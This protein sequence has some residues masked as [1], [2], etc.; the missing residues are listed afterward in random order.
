[1][2]IFFNKRKIN[3]WCVKNITPDLIKSVI[4]LVLSVIILSFRLK[5]TCFSIDN[6]VD[7][8][9]IVS[10]FIVAVCG[11]I[12]TI[13]LKVVINITEDAMKISDNYANLVTKYCLEDMFE[14]SRNDNKTIH[15]PV[16]IL[17]QRKIDETPF[18]IIIDHSNKDKRYQLP[19]QIADNSSMLF[20]AHSTSIIYNNINIRVDDW[21]YLKEKNEVKLRYSKT[22]YYDSLLTNRVM[23]YP[24]K[25][26]RTIREVFEPGPLLSTLSES[27][28]S[29][30]IGF[31]G[32]IETADGFYIFVKRAKNLSIAKN[33]LSTSVSA[34]LKTKYALIKNR[35]LTL[36]GIS[37]AIKKEVYDELKI[38]IDADAGTEIDLSKSIFAFYRELS[39]GGKPQFLMYYKLKTATKTEIDKNFQILLKEKGKNKNDPIEDGSIIKFYT[40]DDLRKSE[41]DVGSIKK[42]HNEE[43]SVV[44]TISFSIACLLS[45][46]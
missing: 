20:E 1:M 29:N 40:L 36:D 3:R 23:D 43:Y 44:P 10:F 13:L 30:H 28:L 32:F 14:F 38:D 2:R 25:E 17:S 6:M 34:S 21:K 27:K 4:L 45:S 11:T 19:K 22:T 9:I 26:S 35:E 39:E 18:N 7:T 15:F 5:E 33:T 12:S 42:L 41:L 31:N 16:I 24:F 8:N 37:N 46:L